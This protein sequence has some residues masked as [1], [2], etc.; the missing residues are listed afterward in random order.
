MKL[1]H[2]LFAYKQSVHPYTCGYVCVIEKEHLR[3][4]SVMVR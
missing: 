4:G 3:K 2:R 1:L